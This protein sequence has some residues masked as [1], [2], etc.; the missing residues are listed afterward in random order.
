MG[1]VPEL[2]GRQLYTLM[3]FICGCSFMM[4]GY[5]AGVFGGILLHKPFLDAI[6]N[7]Q[8]EYIIPIISSSYGLAA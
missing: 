6:G 1:I 7:P 8:G 2:R 5:D 4:Y 3:K